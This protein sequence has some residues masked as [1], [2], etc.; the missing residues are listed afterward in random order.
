MPS[1]VKTRLIALQAAETIPNTQM[2]A[3]REVVYR[4]ETRRL[5][6]SLC[7]SVFAFAVSCRT[8]L[9]TT[10]PR[11]VVARPLGARASKSVVFATVS[12]RIMNLPNTSSRG[13][14]GVK[15]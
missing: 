7:C 3:T 2:E 6:F 10:S 13:E 14:S 4:S 12:I 11:A 8:L 1:P 15:R 9:G 5:C